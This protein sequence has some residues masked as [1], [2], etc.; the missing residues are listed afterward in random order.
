MMFVSTIR[1]THN[2]GRPNGFV[3]K[4]KYVV[5]EKCSEAVESKLLKLETSR[6]VILPPLLSV[7]RFN[8]RSRS[9]PSA[10]PVRKLDH[11]SASFRRSCH[12][13]LC[14]RNILLAAFSNSVDQN[15]TVHQIYQ[16]LDI[17]FL[18]PRYNCRLCWL[19]VLAMW[20]DWAIT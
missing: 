18:D 4:W 19:A 9:K 5:F 12:V 13:V 14:K 17:S 7:I 16:I 10:E 20:L 11:G 2:P 8:I 1:I 6:T 3:Q 15:A